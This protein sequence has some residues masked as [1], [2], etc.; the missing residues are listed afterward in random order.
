[1]HSLPLRCLCLVL[2]LA[3]AAVLPSA[4][5]NIAAGS[6]A[7]RSAP[8]GA[9]VTILALIASS[10]L[11]AISVSSLPGLNV[12]YALALRDERPTRPRI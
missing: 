11:V 4:G 9:S 1:M 3:A 5:A 7:V 8:G 6:L 10:L 12:R 2:L